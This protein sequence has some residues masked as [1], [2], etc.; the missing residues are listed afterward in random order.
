MKIAMA[1]AR[2]R[3]EAASPMSVVT[4]AAPPFL[5]V[6]GTGDTI[7]P[8]VEAKV[9]ADVLR[10]V[11]RRP[12]TLLEVHHA[13]HAFDLL[14]SLRTRAVL[15]HVVAFCER[16]VAKQPG[17]AGATERLAVVAG[18]DAEAAADVQPEVGR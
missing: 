11:S 3:Y 1:D 5:I 15:E 12:L 17:S 6:Q 7:V 16:V 10:G 18:G 8:P 4:D 13:Q 14:A 9:F 2:D